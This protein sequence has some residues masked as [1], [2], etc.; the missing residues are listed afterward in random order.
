M[1]KTKWKIVAIVF[2]T[3]FT[4][5]LLFN[6]WG[7]SLYMAETDSAN[8]CYYDILLGS[9]ILSVFFVAIDLCQVANLPTGFSNSLIP[10]TG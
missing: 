8:E 5:L 9:L 6:I 7:I 10:L 2:I 4:L 3:L 1:E